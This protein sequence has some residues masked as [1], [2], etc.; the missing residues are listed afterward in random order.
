[1]SLQLTEP[2]QL[3]TSYRLQW[4]EAQNMFVLLYPEG[5]IELNQSSAEI[6]SL[7]DGQHTLDNIVSVLEVKFS[8]T[9]IK[10]DITHF[11]TTAL[12]NGWITQNT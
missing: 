7:C 6:L 12:N 8:T 2:F 5:L 9:G 11:L 3:L 1:M 10:N 4:E